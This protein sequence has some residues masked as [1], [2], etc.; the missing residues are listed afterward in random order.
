MSACSKEEQKEK[1][2]LKQIKIAVIQFPGS[3]C[4]FETKRAVESVGMKAQI[5]RWNRKAKELRGY[6]GY[7]IGGGF[8]Y[9]DRVR[10][11]SI[12]AKEPIMETIFQEAE[13][14]KPLLGICNGAQVLVETGIIPGINPGEVEMALAP[15][16]MEKEGRIIRRDYY[17][18]W[19]NLRQEVEGR[20]CVFTLLLNKEEVLPIPIAHGEGRFVSRKEGLLKR[21]IKNNQIVLRYCTSLGEIKEE[22]PV[23]PNGSLYNIAGVC[24]PQGNVLALMPHPE[25]ANWLR[26]VP[27]EIEGEWAK[28]KL[29][30]WG[31]Q[32]LMEGEGPGRKVFISMKKY[33]LMAHSSWEEG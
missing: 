23:N 25:R 12:A 31:K 6:D 32:G 30:A 20:R 5:F 22:F 14:G 17:C 33:I 21:L 27:S 15:N 7:I 29:R 2:M 26:Q 10:A 13:K 8:S 19:I 16:K 28:E 3:N 24:N 11:G 18:N 9:Q 4:E 1:K